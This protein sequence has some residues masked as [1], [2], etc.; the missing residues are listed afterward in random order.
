MKILRNS[1]AAIIALFAVGATIASQAKVNT[2]TLVPPSE[3]CFNAEALTTPSEPGW[4]APLNSNGEQFINV[5][6]AVTLTGIETP[7]LVSDPASE[8]PNPQQTVCCY[9][10]EETS[11]GVFQIVRVYYKQSI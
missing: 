8:C 1:L 6:P 7:L 11:S 9:D 3:G 10:I 5:S 2:G 4:Q